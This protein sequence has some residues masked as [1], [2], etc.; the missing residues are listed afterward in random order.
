MIRVLKLKLMIFVIGY[1]MT[2]MVREVNETQVE[3]EELLADHAYYYSREE[4]KLIIPK[5]E[6]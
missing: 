5:S 4:K 2:N 3:A 1:E 6:Q